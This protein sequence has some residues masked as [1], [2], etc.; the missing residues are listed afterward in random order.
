MTPCPAFTV[1]TGLIAEKCLDAPKRP[2]L[3]IT[4][5]FYG[6]PHGV[7]LGD[8]VR[9]EVALRTLRRAGRLDLL[10]GAGPEGAV[11]LRK[12]LPERAAPSD[13]PTP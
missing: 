3:V 2:P 7:V 13:T 4:A 5:D 10:A 1:P 8:Q 12:P 6:S 9:T 11:S